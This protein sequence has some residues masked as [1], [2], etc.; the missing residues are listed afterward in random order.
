MSVFVFGSNLAG[1]HG[2]GAARDAW[3]QHGA[4]WGVGVGYRGDSYAIP[5]KDD[6]LKPLPLEVIEQ[7]VKDF[8]SFA[9]MRSDL[10]FEV[11]RVGCGLAG[12]FEQ[13]I[14]PLF[15]GAP[16]NCKLPSGWREKWN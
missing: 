10:E 2:K 13:E 6:C 3:K 4:E 9:E 14:G 8:L 16:T 1:I 15:K 12:Y 11:T 5:T 7:H